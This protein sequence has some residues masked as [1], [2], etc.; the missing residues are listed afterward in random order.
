M[1]S[2]D[3]A[4]GFANRFLPVAVRR[5]K[6]LPQPQPMDPE[7]RRGLQTRFGTAMAVARRSGD[8]PLSPG[9][10]E[11]WRGGIYHELTA[12]RP[13]MLGSL[14]ARSEPYVLRLALTYALLTAPAQ[15]SPITFGPP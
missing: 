15:S 3:L 13:G 1:T 8:I 5:T 12:D 7:V 10:A 14:T 4:G 6:G 11:M 2:L 9:A